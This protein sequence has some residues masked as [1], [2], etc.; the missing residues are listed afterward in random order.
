[1]VERL[2]V[3]EVPDILPW[4]KPKELLITTGYPLRDDP[5]VLT[6]LVADLD[7][8]GLGALGV[9]LGRYLPELPRQMLA[10]ADQRGFPVIRLPENVAFSD[11][12]EQVAAHAANRQAA[13]VSSIGKV[14]R[15][16]VQIVL[17]GGGLPE[18]AT[19]LGQLLGAAIL[20]TTPEG[21]VLA[22]GG[23]VDLLA[24]VYDSASCD[25]SGRLRTESIGN[26]LGTVSGLPGNQIVVPVVAGHVDHGRIAAFS[27]DGQLHPDDVPALMAAATAAA[28]ALTAQLA[29]HAV[30]SKYQ[31]DFLR[32]MIS[33]HV[34][35][36]QAIAHSA[37]L[38]WNVNRPVVVLVAEYGPVADGCR[39]DADRTGA[40]ENSA[41]ENSK[42]L[43][44]NSKISRVDPG[45]PP[46]LAP[47]SALEQFASAWQAVIRLRDPY[48][49]VA[50]FEREVVAVLGAPPD[51][52]VD[53]LVRSLVREVSCDGRSGGGDRRGSF[54]TGVSRIVASPTFLATA[55]EQ[56]R[57]AVRVGRRMQGQGAVAH[58]DELGVFRLLSLVED[59][60]EL[61]A[62]ADEVLGELT[63]ADD[64]EIADL[65]HTLQV[66]LEHS[67]NVAETA[68][69]LHFHYN[70]LRYRIAKLERL[71][72][73][74]TQDSDL[75][76]SLQLALLVLQMHG[77]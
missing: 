34:S 70:T 14:H 63:R 31:G 22:N 13:A 17:D 64:A 42:D 77:G 45:D 28:L 51:G 35:P 60:A 25:P 5:E 26:G 39:P 1:M 7:T 62:F 66:L 15:A 46:L 21:R 40:P 76:L 43:N 53:R 16:L 61:R 30:E 50:G 52:D 3:M 20:I 33:G 12:L 57:T 6:R 32:D 19:K 11:I 49:P 2:N 65:R 55:Y 27:P 47:Y 41:P 8:R 4:T 68:R 9:K 23:D 24:G 18:V 69:V 48:A 44:G 75:R 73:P 72:G 71:L 29:V 54:S 74:F 67:L 59:Q 56:A 58:F 37:S 10:E 36:D 38:G